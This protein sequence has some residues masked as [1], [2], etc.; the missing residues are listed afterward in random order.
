MST[1]A[2]RLGSISLVC[3]PTADQDRAI[4]FYESIGF[5]KR[6]D[7]PFGGGYR[8]VEVYPPTGTAGIALAPPRPGSEVTPVETGI[9]LTTDDADA[10]HAQLKSLGVTNAVLY[11]FSRKTSASEVRA[12]CGYCSVS[13]RKSSFG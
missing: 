1:T 2:T 12:R 7:V 13:S 9:T 4:A 6:T 11:P 8:W 3:I 5:E 10:T